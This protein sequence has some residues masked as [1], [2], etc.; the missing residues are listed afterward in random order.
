MTVNHHASV[1]LIGSA[2]ASLGQRDRARQAFGASL[3][4]NPQEAST[5]TNLGLLEMESG[6]RDAAVAYLA[7]SLTLN[8]HDK[9]ART[10]LSAIMAAQH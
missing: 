6:N 10:T 2:S 4:A 7:E 8:P 5:Y 9:V 1:Y 3:E